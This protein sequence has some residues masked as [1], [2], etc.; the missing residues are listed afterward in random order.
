MLIG[1]NCVIIS[2][3][4]LAKSPIK[5]SKF[6]SRQN[7]KEQLESKWNVFRIVEIKQDN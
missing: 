4:Q 6:D 2:R 7:W 3:K 5:M 1:T